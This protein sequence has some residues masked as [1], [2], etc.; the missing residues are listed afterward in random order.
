[1]VPD[2]EVVLPCRNEA[3][4]LPALLAR[5][6]RHIAVLVVDNGSTDGTADV[7]SALG[8]RVVV[9]RRPGYGAAVRAGVLAA[10]GRYVAVMDADGSLDPSELLPLF[11]DVAQGRA[12]MAVGR[13]R[14]V[15]RG[16]LPWH[17][18]G[19]NDAAAWWLGRRTGMRLHDIPSV[20]VARRADLLALGVQDL[21]FGYP[22]EVLVRAH[23]AGWFL[24]E[25]DMTYRPRAEGT[26]SKVSGSLRGSVTAAY[27]LVRAL[28]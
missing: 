11:E 24:T 23:R 2:C 26:T 14:P 16:V 15:T 17:A 9:E 1:M 8:A 18:R 5:V 12:T 28:P 19:F 3:R 25:H 10:R 22:V 7:A 4:A 27:D 13:R 20:R 21:R 6:P